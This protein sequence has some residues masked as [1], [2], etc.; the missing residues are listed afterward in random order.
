MVLDK[1]AVKTS[2]GRPASTYVS[3]RWPFRPNTG[4]FLAL[5]LRT[6]TVQSLDNVAE[7]ASRDPCR[8]LCSHHLGELLVAHSSPIEISILSSQRAWSMDFQ[9][10]ISLDAC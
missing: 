4:A 1:V 10:L 3:A 9:T 5:V 7:E 6:H 2:I 8:Q